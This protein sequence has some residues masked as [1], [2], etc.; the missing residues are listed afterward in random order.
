M[1]PNQTAEKRIDAIEKRA[2]IDIEIIYG[3][4]FTNCLEKKQNS[5]QE[6]RDI[7]DGRTKPP[8]WCVTTAMQNRWKEKRLKGIF[9]DSKIE[10]AFALQGIIAGEES[11]EIIKRMAERIY[12]SAYNETLESLR[13]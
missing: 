10:N 9:K 12:E 3:K 11:V 7:L 2:L 8:R 1:K 6:I 5:V 4:A 13:G